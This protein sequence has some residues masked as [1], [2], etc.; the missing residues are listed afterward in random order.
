MSKTKEFYHEEIN[1]GMQYPTIL[2]PHIFNYSVYFNYNGT[3]Y[4]FFTDTIERIEELAK[5]LIPEFIGLD[6]GPD[7]KEYV[8]RCKDWE[9]PI[10]YYR[11]TNTRY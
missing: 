3:S 11:N 9:L 6:Y 2:E 8:F 4:S 10:Y 1:A 5:E 7:L